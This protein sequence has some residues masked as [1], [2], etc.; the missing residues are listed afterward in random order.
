[1]GRLV[2][3]DNITSGGA[4]APGKTLRLGG[5]TM[6][7]HSVVE[8]TMT[9]RVIENPLRIDSEHSK[10]MDPTE[11]S[12]LNELLDRIATLGVATDYDRIG[13]KPNQR[14]IKSPPITHQIAVVEERVDNSS[15]ILRT[16]YVQI[17]SLEEPDTYDMSW[18]NMKRALRREFVPPTYTKQLQRQ[19]ENTIQGSKSIDEYFKEIKIA[20]R[21]A[22]K[23]RDS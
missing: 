7:A 1:M 8:P 4:L 15:S 2:L 19:L 20:L 5:F 13:L 21:R 18:P 9:S 23:P 22:A 6:T 16:D 10:K 17:S 14:E 3:K 11:L 12:S